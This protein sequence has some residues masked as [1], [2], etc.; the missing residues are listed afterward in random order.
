MGI[1]DDIRPWSVPCVGE[2]TKMLVSAISFILAYSAIGVQSHP[3]AATDPT[4]SPSSSHGHEYGHS[5]AFDLDP[6]DD[7]GDFAWTL[8]ANLAVG[9]RVEDDGRK[10][11]GDNSEGGRAG[12]GD[13]VSDGGIQAGMKGSELHERPDEDDAITHHHD[14]HPHKRALPSDQPT[15]TPTPT[16]DPGL[17]HHPHL[18]A[19]PVE[20]GR[21]IH[22]AAVVY[23]APRKEVG[24]L[25]AKVKYASGGGRLGGP[26]SGLWECR[27]A[28]SGGETGGAAWE[29][30]LAAWPGDALW[31]RRH[32]DEGPAHKDDMVDPP[33]KIHLNVHRH[34]VT[35]RAASAAKVK[36]SNITL[37]HAQNG[38]SDG[39][40]GHKDK[41]E[42][43][44]RECQADPEFS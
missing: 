6:P 25:V 44:S 29:C 38:K 13:G 4:P 5:H 42:I 12:D 19:T 18:S 23:G 17:T 35:G 8:P 1:R 33:A 24:S 30:E 11:G 43:W 27:D 7:G 22:T 16:H 9:C 32:P 41:G 21:P 28:V 15:P 37:H 34:T 31:S 39:V 26:A 40:G 36:F 14:G 10:F 2:Q 3:P 20:T